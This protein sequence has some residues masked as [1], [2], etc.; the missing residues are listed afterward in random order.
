MRLEL[1][2][3]NRLQLLKL[4]IK[5]L[6]RVSVFKSSFD[7]M[8]RKVADGWCMIMVMLESSFGNNIYNGSSF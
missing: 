6:S 1:P 8:L 2:R 3:M 4:M 5:E 7:Y